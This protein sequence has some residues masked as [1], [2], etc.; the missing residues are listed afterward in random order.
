MKTPAGTVVIIHRSQV[1]PN[2]VHWVRQLPSNVLLGLPRGNQIP[3]QRNLGVADNPGEFILF[4][5][6]DSVP[7]YDTLERLL[8][9]NVEVVGAVVCERF[10][11]WKVCAVK[12]MDPPAR[13]ML[14]DLP[15]QGLIPVPALGTGCLLVRRAVFDQLA[16]PWFQCGQ[17]ISDM[18]LEDSHFC[19]RVKRELGI[20]PF[21]DASVRCGHV[22]EGVVWPGRDGRPYIEFR[23]PTNERV[24]VTEILALDAEV[25]ELVRH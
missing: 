2:L 6:S 16:P 11:P 21:L 23:G 1:D 17:I 19:L 7:P 24:P 18:M 22:F 5:D 20:Q 9:W 8:A 13:W 12:S 10:P 14:A 4:V 25:A 15:R 3:A